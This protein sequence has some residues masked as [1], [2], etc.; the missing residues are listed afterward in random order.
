MPEKFYIER[1]LRP[2]IQI[3]HKNSVFNIPREKIHIKKL[4]KIGIENIIYI[5]IYD[6]YLITICSTTEISFKDPQLY[7]DILCIL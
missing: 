4:K 3:L 7:K 5:Q 2:F 1:E 6:D